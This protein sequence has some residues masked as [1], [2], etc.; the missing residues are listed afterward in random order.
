MN[1]VRRLFP[2][3]TCT[4]DIRDGERALQR[5]CLLY[6][7]KRCQGPCVEAISKDAYA[8][9]IRQVELFLEGN[10]D[11]LVDGLRHE[12]AFAS[13]Q[14]SYE[15]AAVLRDKVRAIEL[16]RWRARRWPP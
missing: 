16:G 14:Q 2:F 9:D 4:I 15:R 8:R 5:P 1:L 6:H 11:A 10:A 3:P 13:E 7:I 12:M